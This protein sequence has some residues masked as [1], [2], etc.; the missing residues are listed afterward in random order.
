MIRTHGSDHL[1][2]RRTNGKGIRFNCNLESSCCSGIEL[3][4]QPSR[5][6]KI[7]NAVDL[8]HVC[9]VIVEQTY[10]TLCSAW[11]GFVYLPRT[12]ATDYSDASQ[13]RY[14]RIDMWCLC[15]QQ[16]AAR[17]SVNI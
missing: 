17:I 2:K 12:S 15:Q 10:P 4:R 1:R 13:Y 8:N 3:E 9:H 16:L 14:A 7:R 11:E 6:I 5:A